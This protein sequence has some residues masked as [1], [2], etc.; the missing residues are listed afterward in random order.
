MK[1]RGILKI[2]T[3]GGIKHDDIIIWYNYK[4]NRRQMQTFIEG[5][6]LYHLLSVKDC[7]SVVFIAM[8]VRLLLIT[9]LKQTLKV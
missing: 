6:A 7:L 8:I 9:F 3:G 4:D 5:C 1:Q 2:E